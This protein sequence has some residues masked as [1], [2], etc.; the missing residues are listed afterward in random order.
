MVEISDT[1]FGLER[2]DVIKFKF[3][4]Q[5]YVLQILDKKDLSWKSVVELL[6]FIFNAFLI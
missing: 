4:L 5:K 2:L 1:I 3:T 6:E